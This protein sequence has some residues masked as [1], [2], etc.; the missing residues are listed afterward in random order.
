MTQEHFGV[1]TETNNLVGG[2]RGYA[3]MLSVIVSLVA[4]VATF[5]QTKNP[6]KEVGRANRAAVT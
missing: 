5:L 2:L 4:L 3:V 6:G 1:T